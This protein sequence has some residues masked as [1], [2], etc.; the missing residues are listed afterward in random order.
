MTSEAGQADSVN[1]DD[2]AGSQK[3]PSHCFGCREPPGQQGRLSSP[4]SLS[5][6][7]GAFAGQSPGCA[8][9]AAFSSAPLNS[10]TSPFPSDRSCG[11][12]EFRGKRAPLLTLKS[13]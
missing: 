1:R 8:E 13:Y 12:R 9:A 10:T 11:N 6:A 4:Q 2:Y 7:A 3:A 5:R